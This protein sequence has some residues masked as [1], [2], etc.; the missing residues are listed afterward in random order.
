[1]IEI[2]RKFLVKRDFQSLFTTP[3]KSSIHM[4]QAYLGKVRIRIEKHAGTKTANIT[5]K[6]P[7]Q[8]GGLSRPEWEIPM[9]SEVAEEIILSLDPPKL[10]KFRTP[11]CDGEDEWVVD[12]L[13]VGPSDPPRFLVVAEFEHEDKSRVENLFIPFWVGTEVTGDPRFSMANLATEAQ[14]EEAW[15]LTTDQLL[16][17]GS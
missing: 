8:D 2:E 11:V 17:E 5:I 12:V 13:E 14:R 9:L 6:G 3:T 4:T 10:Q 16:E 7:S 1:M 15:L